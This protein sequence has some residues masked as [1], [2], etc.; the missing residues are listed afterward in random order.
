MEKKGNLTKIL[1]VTGTGLA[2][3]PVLAPVLFALIRLASGRRVIL[4]YLMPAELF[5]VALLGGGLLI[6]AALRAR[7]RLPIIAW[8]LGLAVG[9][10]VAGQA[11]AVGSGLASGAIR[12][13]GIWWALVV[14]SLAVYTLA[15]I[16]VAVGGTL[17]IRD[18]FGKKAVA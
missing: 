14:A 2:W 16:A 13:E 8:G 17:L 9:V 18:L 10:L 15:L 11:V 4:D 12:P 1:A 6:W 5:P 7:S 3:L